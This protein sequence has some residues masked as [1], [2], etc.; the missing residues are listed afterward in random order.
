MRPR[1]SLCGG[2]KRPVCG[3]VGVSPYYTGDPEMLEMPEP[4]LSSR[5]S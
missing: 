4:E 3:A 2:S 1:E 5:G